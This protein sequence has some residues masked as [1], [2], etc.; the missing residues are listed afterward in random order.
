M[1]KVI[2]KRNDSLNK[3]L[4]N[5]TNIRFPR[6]LYPKRHKIQKSKQ[7]KFNEWEQPSEQ[8]KR[9]VIRV[10]SIDNLPEPAVQG[11]N[12]CIYAES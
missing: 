12:E 5:K 11:R 2:A 10:P 8:A 7:P 9:S 4:F 3:E 1:Y 6:H